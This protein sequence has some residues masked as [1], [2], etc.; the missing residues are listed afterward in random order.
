MK[1][2][3]LVCLLALIISPSFIFSQNT[4][5]DQPT[6]NQPSEPEVISPNKP[7]P[8]TQTPPV[9]IKRFEGQLDNVKD[10]TPIEQDAPYNVLLKYI[11]RL[12]QNEISAKIRP[13]TTFDD[14][15]KTPE[16]YRG[17]IIRCK[18]VLLFLNPYTLRSN[19][20]GVDTYY[21]GMLGNPS[22]DEFYF[23]HLIDKPAEPLK[24]LTDDHSQADEVEVEGAFLKI[25]LYELD[26]R[27][28]N[29]TDKTFN[30]APLIIGRKITKVIHPPPEAAYKFQWII[31]FVLVA[32]LA[33]IF[34][35]VLIAGRKE[36][37]E[38]M[39]LFGKHKPAPPPKKNNS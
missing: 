7:A 27:A 37:R 13:E 23:F 2:S 25:A 5:P 35:F 36:R 18:G 31:I 6:T 11:S 4:T 39:S 24:N 1:I 26:A 30:A 20:A 19:T 14:L 8:I 28:K 9:I 34:L 17:E 22:T 10:R 12:N 38:T 15:M 32:V 3:V 29:R 16:K 33:F 21:S